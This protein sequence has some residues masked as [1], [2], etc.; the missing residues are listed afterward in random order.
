MRV[1]AVH[2]QETVRKC[3]K[4]CSSDSQCVNIW[5]AHL[6][7]EPCFKSLR[8]VLPRPG[9]LGDGRYWMKNAE[10][11]AAPPIPQILSI[12]H[13][14]QMKHIPFPD[15][16][17]SASPFRGTRLNQD[18]QSGRAC[19]IPFSFS[20]SCSYPECEWVRCMIPVSAC[21]SIWLSYSVCKDLYLCLSYS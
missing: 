21:N 4:D 19:F 18:V 13:P 6:L 10:Q 15:S 12:N 14:P 9:P 3:Q 5:K 1:I 17:T 11:V 16:C 8:N 20:E 2:Q 7:F